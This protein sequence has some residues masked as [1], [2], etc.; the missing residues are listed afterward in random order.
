M[1]LQI[2][3]GKNSEFILVSIEKDWIQDCIHMYLER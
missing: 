1:P 2:F 3:P